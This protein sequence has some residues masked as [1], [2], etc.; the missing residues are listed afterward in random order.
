MIWTAIR[1]A[2]PTVAGK[3]D[4]RQGGFTLLE[5]LATLAIV[6]ILASMAVPGMQSLFTH[7]RIANDYND[8]AGGLRQARSMAISEGESVSVTLAP[9]EGGGWTLTFDDRSGPPLRESFR[10]NSVTRT[11]SVMF[12][13]VGRLQCDSVSLC[14]EVE[15]EVAGKTLWISPIGYIGKRN[16]DDT[17]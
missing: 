8:I 3:Q 6:A 14:P 9:R 4:V 11:R 5:L 15:I 7:N 2:R 13:D 12:N 16:D 10:G 1:I 17:P